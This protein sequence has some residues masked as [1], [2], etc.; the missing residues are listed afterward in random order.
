VEDVTSELPVRA[1]SA[2]ERSQLVSRAGVREDGTPVRILDAH[3]WV[4]K[5]H[6]KKAG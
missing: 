2:A 1:P 5:A 4:A 3:R 6:G